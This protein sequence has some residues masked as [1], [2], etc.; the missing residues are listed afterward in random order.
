MS[1]PLSEE[2]WDSRVLVGGLFTEALKHVEGET[3]ENGH[4]ILE[5]RIPTPTAEPSS[6]ERGPSSL[7]F[8]RDLGVHTTPGICSRQPRPG[9]EPQAGLTCK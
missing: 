9:S 6:L 5:R 8:N 1:Q 3:K 2:S 4:L 7:A